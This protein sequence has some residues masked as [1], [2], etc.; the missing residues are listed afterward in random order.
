MTKTPAIAAAEVKWPE[1]PGASSVQGLLVDKGKAAGSANTSV[2]SVKN[3]PTL[4]EAVKL[5]VDRQS[6]AFAAAVK[7]TPNSGQQSL[8]MESSVCGA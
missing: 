7:K 1:L 5:W 3:P 2:I 8:A 6:Q 4:A